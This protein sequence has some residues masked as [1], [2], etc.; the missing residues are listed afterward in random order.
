MQ[1][2]KRSFWERV[3]VRQQ[4]SLDTLYKLSEKLH[5]PSEL[6]ALGYAISVL[7][8]R[9]EDSASRI[10]R[11]R[12]QHTPFRLA[13]LIKRVFSLRLFSDPKL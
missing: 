12:K 8:D 9:I 13:W 1:N 3:L 2:Q 5:E 7:E 6:R 4:R 10:Q 11:E